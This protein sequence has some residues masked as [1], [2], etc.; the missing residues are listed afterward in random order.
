VD[1]FDVGHVQNNKVVSLRR[2]ILETSWEVFKKGDIFLWCDGLQKEPEKKIAKAS[3]QQLT[4]LNRMVKIL[5]A[6]ITKKK[7]MKK[8]N[9]MLKN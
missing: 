9:A 7:E 1:Q 3:R 6:N 8:T 2:R 5:L 4:A